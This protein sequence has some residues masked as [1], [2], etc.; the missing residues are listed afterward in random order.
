VKKKQNEMKL[1]EDKVAT[2]YLECNNERSGRRFQSTK[3]HACNTS[4]ERYAAIITPELGCCNMDIFRD[5]SPS[6]S[7]RNELSRI[8]EKIGPEVCNIVILLI[9][10]LFRRA[11]H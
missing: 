8:R 1:L 6:I 3:K 11:T 5:S 4:Y 10:T 2:E 9:Y 7:V